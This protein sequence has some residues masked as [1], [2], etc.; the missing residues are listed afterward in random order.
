[1]KTAAAV[2]VRVVAALL[3]GA[4]LVAVIAQPR[5]QAAAQKA[6][7]Q[8]QQPQ[9]GDASMPGFGV[10]VH[11]LPDKQTIGEIKRFDVEAFANQ[12]AEMRASH[13]ILTLGQNNGQYIAPNSALEVLCP[14]SA[15]NR[16]PRDLPLEIGQ[17]LRS[18]GIALILYL[19]FR[20]P[21]SDRYLM[22]CLGDVNE[23]QPPPQKFVA[24]WASVIRDWSEH[25][26]P[27]AAGWWFD[28]TYNT[29][30][31]TSAGWDQLCDASRSGAANRLL[32][33][34]AGEGA[35]RFALKSAPCQNL[36]AGEYMEPPAR[37]AGA[38]TELMFHVLTPLTASWGRDGPPRFTPA[39]LRNW[40]SEAATTRGLFTLDMPVDATGRFVAAHVALI[41]GLTTRKP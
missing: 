10:M 38:P 40:M 37:P 13:L 18:R 41:R 11:Y 20:A 5:P 23:Q 15:K 8:P 28:G 9:A 3:L 25:Y 33:F 34:N 26:G 30:G 16:S 4:A 24:A 31:I 21:Q 19:P 39:Q 2:G 6:A 22:G 14:E 12:L 1:M 17:A 29:K 7:Q 32:A 36:M 35:E 27:L